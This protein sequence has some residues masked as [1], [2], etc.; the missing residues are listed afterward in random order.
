M[1]FCLAKNAPIYERFGFI[2]IAAP[3]I[4]GGQDMGDEAMWK[5]LARRD[6]AVRPVNL[7]QLPF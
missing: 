2:R 6:V 7:P 5:P 3:V 4:A 1:L